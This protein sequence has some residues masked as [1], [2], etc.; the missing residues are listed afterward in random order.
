MKNAVFTIFGNLVGLAIDGEPSIPKNIKSLIEPQLTYTFQKRLFGVDRFDPNTGHKRDFLFQERKLY[1][2]DAS[3]RMCFCIGF[4]ERVSDIVKK[5]GYTV[6]YVDISPKLPRKN[7]YKPVWDN[8]ADMS[9]KAKQDVA[10]ASVAAHH[11]GVIVAPPAFGKS[12]MLLFICKLFPHAKIDIITKRKDIVLKTVRFLTKYIPS[13]GQVGGGKN[14]YSRVTVFTA[15]SLHK[16]KFDADIILVDEAHELMADSYA[17][18]LSKYRHARAY[19]FTA[20]P[21]GRKDGTDARLE[22]IFGKT[23]FYMSYQEAEALGVV[24]PIFIDWLDIQISPNPCAGKSDVPKR[25]WGLWRNNVRNS[26]IASHLTKNYKEEQVL[27]LVDTIEHALYLRKYLPDYS[28]C[29]AENG[30]TDE[31]HEFYVKQKLMDKD[32]VIIDA[33]IRE[34]L[35]QDFESGKLK[36]VIA[37]GV[38][39]T[40]VDFVNLQV[41]VRADG[42]DGEIIDFQA[43]GRVCRISSTKQY[44]IVVDCRDQFDPGLH[45]KAKKREKNYK[46]K[47]WKNISPKML[48]EKSGEQEK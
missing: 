48:K 3:N 46:A 23:I 32:E 13:I 8:I 10:V 36:K 29:Y 30:I 42:S 18:Q 11:R 12:F 25:R 19:A 33:D 20:T 44:G 40:G 27:V 5:A 1:K 26:I 17:S 9:F 43:P 41:L 45:R 14:S 6:K 31:E 7:C 16:S 22:S 21:K 39:S 28:L 24:T 37:T 35:R 38:W 4:I 15:D 2:Y 34:Q 47:G